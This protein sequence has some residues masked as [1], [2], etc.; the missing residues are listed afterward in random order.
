MIE[1]KDRLQNVKIMQLHTKGAA[2]NAA[3]GMEQHYNWELALFQMQF[4]LFY[5]IIKI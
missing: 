5:V 4:C 3:E 1:H 2:P